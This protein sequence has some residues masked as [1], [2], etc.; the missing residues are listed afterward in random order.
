MEIIP[1]MLPQKQSQPE[2]TTSGFPLARPFTLKRSGSEPESTVKTVGFLC[3]VPFSLLQLKETSS[4]SSE[5][6]K[7]PTGNTDGG[8]PDESEDDPVD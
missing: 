6:T 1:T 3:S 4:R 7:N 2:L 5:P 8:E